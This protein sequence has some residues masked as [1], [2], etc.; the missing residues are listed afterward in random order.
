[1]YKSINDFLLKVISHKFFNKVS[2]LL[3]LALYTFFIYRHLVA[4]EDRSISP[5][6]LVIVLM[7]TV[8]LTLILVRKDPTNRAKDIKSWFFAFAGTFLPLLLIPEGS[9]LNYPLGNYLII[10]GG[11][12]AIAS[13]L[14]LNNSFGIS[15]ALREVKVSGL[16][17][18]IRHP[19]YFSYLILLTG[20]VILIFSW[21]NLLLILTVITCLIIRIILEEKI[22]NGDPVYREYTKRVKYR[23]IPFIF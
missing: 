6:T 8:V 4:V 17:S 7:E 19:I 14:S 5:A 20:Y 3:L 22:L 12:L 1:M 21:F 9:V 13:Y 10:I 2:N 11:L 16:Y 15:P 18:F 23:L